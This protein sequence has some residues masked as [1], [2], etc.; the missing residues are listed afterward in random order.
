[1]DSILCLLDPRLS[2]DQIQILEQALSGFQVHLLPIANDN[3]T[4]ERTA[5]QA[6]Q[7]LRPKLILLP[8]QL[9][10]RD[11]SLRTQLMGLRAKGPTPIAY[12]CDP[13]YAPWEISAAQSPS[14]ID[15]DIWLNACALKPES[16][17]LKLFQTTLATLLNP[18]AASGLHALRGHSVA[19]SKQWNAV[20]NPSTA[21][22]HLFDQA[23]SALEFQDSS[24][25]PWPVVRLA[26]L[27]AWSWAIEGQRNESPDALVQAEIFQNT[28]WMRIVAGHQP[29]PATRQI[30][31]LSWAHLL[32][33]SAHWIRLQTIGGTGL[34]ELTFGV[35]LLS[36]NHQPHPTLI[37]TT[38]AEGT[39]NRETMPTPTQQEQ[40]DARFWNAKPGSRAHAESL[41]EA[42]L[43]IE[44]L[45]H[46]LKTKDLALQ[47]L[48]AGGVGMAFFDGLN[49]NEQQRYLASLVARLKGGKAA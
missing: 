8:T 18:E 44:T 4:P 47:E 28:L 9:Y 46:Q 10:F 26:L 30:Q 34:A 14:E 19:P 15:R 17:E 11:S 22:A 31:D 32:R 37:L 23:H 43:R 35:S 27:A 7:Q 12:W 33:L 45:Q 40:T 38:I 41:K 13:L 1:M 29:W 24:A 5:L 21:L 39:L 25:H 6:M 49:P 2:K 3:A 36:Q 42:R 16:S 48:R 20:W